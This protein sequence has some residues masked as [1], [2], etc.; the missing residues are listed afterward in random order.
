VQ[1]RPVVGVEEIDTDDALGA[2]VVEIDRFPSH[3]SIV[4]A[5]LAR[6]RLT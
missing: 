5:I 2:E 4:R 6:W 1:C 3:A